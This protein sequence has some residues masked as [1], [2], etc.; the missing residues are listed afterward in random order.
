MGFYKDN[1]IERIDYNISS[2]NPKVKRLLRG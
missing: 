2:N 1:G